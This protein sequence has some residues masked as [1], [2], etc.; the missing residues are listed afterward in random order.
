[1]TSLTSFS[2]RFVHPLS[3]QPQNRVEREKASE[4]RFRELETLAQ[5]GETKACS[6]RGLRQYHC[7]LNRQCLGF[8]RFL[9]TFAR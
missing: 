3:L 2:R 6:V 5:S 8:R 9:L 4:D 1:M 7:R